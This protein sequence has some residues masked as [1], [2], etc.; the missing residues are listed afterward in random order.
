MGAGTIAVA[1]WPGQGGPCA[2]IVWAYA[3]ISAFFARRR[4]GRDRIDVGVIT[5]VLGLLA[6]ILTALALPVMPSPWIGALCLL[7]GAIGRRFPGG[8]SCS[9]ACV[10]LGLAVLDAGA[11][12]A[13]RLPPSAGGRDW[14]LSGTVETLLSSRPDRLTFLFRPDGEGLDDRIPKRIRLVWYS[15]P[16]ELRSGEQWR[17]LVRLR[18]PRGT[19]NPHG[20]DYERWLLVRGVGATGYVRA[21]TRNRRVASARGALDRARGRISDAIALHLGDGQAGRLLEALVTGSRSGLSRETRERLASTGTAHLL[22]ISGLHVGI[23]AASGAALG[24]LLGRMKFPGTSAFAGAGRWIGAVVVASLYANLVGFSVSTRRALVMLLIAALAAIRRRDAV[25]PRG[26]LLAVSC[27]LLIQP[28]A[29]LDSGFWLSFGAVAILYL[30]FAGRVG[31]SGRVA[32]LVRAQAVLGVGMVVPSL[33][34]FTYVP[35]TGFLV[36]LVAVPLVS[37]VVLPAGLL[38]AVVALV[39]PSGAGAPFG[40]AGFGLEMLLAVT[41]WFVERAP[42]PLAPGSPGGWYLA[43]SAWAC[44]SLIGNMAFPGRRA[45]A[46]VLVPLLLWRGHAPPPEGFDITI[47]DVGQGLAAVIRT[48]HHVL[49]YDAGPAWPGGDAGAMTVRPYL[50]GEGISSPDV[51]MISHGD[52]DHA[53]GA[54]SLMKSSPKR[55]LAGPGTGLEGGPVHVCRSGQAWDWDGVRFELLHPAAGH[56]DS[57]ND[58]SCVLRVSS[59]AGSVLLPGDIEARVEKVL[60]REHA[61]LAADLVVAPHHGSGTS[62]TAAF[63]AATRPRWVVYASGYGNRWGFPRAEVQARWRSVGA[64]SADTGRDGA[65]RFIFR[66]GWDEPEIRRW[67]CCSQR[68]WR[69][70]KCLADHDI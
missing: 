70:R 46:L 19:A 2:K 56:E 57:G 36:N 17:L 68:F 24:G 54:V 29:P 64:S 45:A 43:L 5:G 61:D 31:R 44:A 33:L 60:V 10:G 12:I 25:F 9:W 50:R 40:L 18:E 51:L 34:F 63:V 8:R 21:S 38:G 41:G 42:A 66:P 13:D 7:L 22:A 69:P 11:L 67:R 55:I 32:G 28:T 49:V 65:V 30:G 4:I 53:G 26:L 37:L 39:N 16:A 58:A 27:T 35:L 62:S 47:L 15:A 14:L 6:G 3:K 23:S 59:T 52:N 1:T 48:R 20:F